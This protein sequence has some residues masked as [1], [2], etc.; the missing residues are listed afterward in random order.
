MRAPVI[1]ILC[2]GLML[3]SGGC[4]RRSGEAGQGTVPASANASDEALSSDEVAPD[5]DEGGGEQAFKHVIDR[6]HA[7]KPMPGDRFTSADGKPV[8]LAKL[9]GGK[10]LLV[11]LWA[12]WCA[13]CIAELPALVKLASERKDITVLAVSQDAEGDKSVTP[14]L[15]KRG[16]EALP[17]ALDPENGLGF[18]YATGVLPTTV[19]YDGKG[20]EVLRVVGALDWAGGDGKAL[21]DGIK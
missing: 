16:L 11:N 13:P 1:L 18:A 14:F 17:I 4:D 6:S 5:G 21:I 15:A 10:P 20:K 3:A 12:T 2:G 19:L 8:T 9:A 7:G